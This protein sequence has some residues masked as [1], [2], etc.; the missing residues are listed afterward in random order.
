MTT[1]KKDRRSNWLTWITDVTDM[2][3]LR[4]YQGVIDE[5][6]ARDGWAAGYTPDEYVAFILN[7]E[8]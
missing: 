6:A 1:K 4:E 3:K 2:L 5:Q 8:R 7:R